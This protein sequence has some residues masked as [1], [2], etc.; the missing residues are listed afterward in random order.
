MA[1]QNASAY[2]AERLINNMETS[3]L[4][5]SADAYHALIFAYAK[6]GKSLA[7]YKTLK[8]IRQAGS[9]HHFT[10]KLSGLFLRE[11]GERVQLLKRLNIDIGDMCLA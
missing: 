9:V 1:A 7:A 8:G 2:D 3:G 11:H 5:I 4:D 6:A 10:H